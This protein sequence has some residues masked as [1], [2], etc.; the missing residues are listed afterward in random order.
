MDHQV[1]FNENLNT[2]AVQL[3]D[4]FNMVHSREVQHKA[5]FPEESQWHGRTYIAYLHANP[6]AGTGL[7]IADMERVASGKYTWQETVSG[8]ATLWLQ[9]K[10]QQ[11]VFYYKQKNYLKIEATLG[12][13]AANQYLVEKRQDALAPLQAY[14]REMELHM[15]CYYY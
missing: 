4:Y 8:K 13:D 10:I 7:I 3:K 12:T 11:E 2:C 1:E 5:L 9:E 6:G 15:Q 14:L